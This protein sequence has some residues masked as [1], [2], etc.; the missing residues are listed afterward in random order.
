MSVWRGSI[1]LIRDGEPVNAKTTNR[2]LAQL[3]ARTDYLKSRF[4]A[5][6]TG[7]SI[8]L[9]SQ[10]TSS[11]VE[12]GDAVYFD[13]SDDVYKPA[14]ASAVNA[15]NGQLRT[16]DSAYVAGIVIRKTSNTSADILMSGR[17]VG[18]TLT[19]NL[20]VALPEGHYYLSA[21][22]P[23]K[24]TNQ[25]PPVGIYVCS[26]TSNG[27]LVNP[28]NREVLEDHVHYAFE[29]ETDPAGIATCGSTTVSLHSENATV[30][31][32]LSANNSVFSGNAPTGAK[33]GYNW[34]ANPI[35]AAI[36]PP[37]P[38]KSAY[39]ELNGVGVH[40]DRVIVD[41]NGIWWM[42]DCINEVPWESNFCSSSSAIDPGAGACDPT[43]R[44]MKLYFTRMISKTDQAAVT[45]IRAAEDSAIVVS[46]CTNPDSSGYCGSRVTLDWQPTWTRDSG[47]TGGEVVKG[48]S[49]S[50][51]QVGYVVE[52]VQGAGLISVSGTQSLSGNFKAGL[53]TIEGLDPSQLT[54][55]LDI[56]ILALDG[57]VEAVYSGILP[58]AGFPKNRA[59]SL[60]GKIRVPDVQ[61]VTPTLDL[62]IWFAAITAGN[63]PADVTIS[64][65][66]MSTTDVFNDGSLVPEPSLPVLPTAWSSP[67]DL[68][69]DTVGALTAG[70][71]FSA[72]ALSITVDSDDVVLFKVTRSASDGY[73]GELGLV[74]MYGL[75]RE[76]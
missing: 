59:S 69:L 32:W 7:E 8:I 16:A 73:T 26:I 13:F 54:R 63:M 11:D 17:Y 4:D 12:L 65:A 37:Q 5:S 10:E 23:G 30:E 48:I 45:G 21:M 60:I 6:S 53:L 71:Y 3:I 27:I 42:T 39:V 38:V 14:I 9:F 70:K 36:W 56:Q 31:G 66:K 61:Y 29:L 40:P 55:K 18:L 46:G 68:N 41:E 58:Y 72:Q 75:I 25:R 15:D 2:P 20:S 52:G 34:T 74:N 62:Y 24:L 57:A 1:D 22:Y 51:L 76:A 64:Y 33:F 50:E 47:T 28:N 43:R 19:D 35:I 67:V 49:N 44:I